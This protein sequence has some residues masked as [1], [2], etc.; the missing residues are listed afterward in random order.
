MYR[1]PVLPD[2]G[3]DARDALSRYLAGAPL[4]LALPTGRLSI[5]HYAAPPSPLWR[6]TV[7]APRW[8]CARELDGV[9]RW[10]RWERQLCALPEARGLARWYQRLRAAHWARVAVHRFLQDAAAGSIVAYAPKGEET[11]ASFWESDV[12]FDPEFGAVFYRCDCRIPAAARL[13]F[14]R[15]DDPSEAAIALRAM[16]LANGLKSTQTLLARGK[17]GAGRRK[18]PQAAPAQAAAA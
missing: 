16:R 12:D 18:P 1:A 8:N 2:N 3:L 13:R 14:H 9:E 7:P 11:P 15:A 6:R 10:Q 4:P 5:R 17:L